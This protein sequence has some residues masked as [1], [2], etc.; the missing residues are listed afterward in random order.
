MI[1]GPVFSVELVTTTR[2]LRYLFIRTAFAALMLLVLWMNYVAVFQEGVGASGAIPASSIQRGAAFAATFFRSFAW[3]Q[4]IVVCVIGPIAV[5]GTISQERERRTIEYLFA[6]TLSNGEIVLGKLAVRIMQVVAVMAA[7]LPVLSLAMLLGGI[8]PLELGGFM[9]LSMSTLL[10]VASISMLQSVLSDRVRSA[11]TKSYSWLFALFL[12]PMIVRWIPWITKS[13]VYDWIEPVIALLVR[14][15]PFSLMWHWSMMMLTSTIW[16]ELLFLLIGH[17]VIGAGCLVI[18]VSVV[19]RSHLSSV[20]KGEK[21]RKTW[22]PR[23]PKVWEKAPLLWKETLVEPK[24]Q[25]RGIIGRLIQLVLFLGILGTVIGFLVYAHRYSANENERLNTIVVPTMIISVAL[26][27]GGVLFAGSRSAGAVCSEKEQQSWESLLSTDLSATEVV[28]GKMFGSL[29]S[30][31]PLF[32]LVLSICTAPLVLEPALVFVLVAE[33]VTLTILCQ[34]A[35]V[36]GT[37]FSLYCDSSLRAIGATICMITLIG[38]GYIFFLMPLF[39]VWEP[40][41]IVFAPVVPLLLGC[42][43]VFYIESQR[44]FGGD[45]WEVMFTYF[46]GN[47]GYLLGSIVLA[48]ATTLNFQRLSGRLEPPLT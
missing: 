8:P 15:S 27:L 44:G 33:M 32:F 36:L 3:L 18:S 13:W 5:S 43:F 46:L 17:A 4:L 7:G 42:P 39:I 48:A 40:L 6:T 2:R 38:G 25:R 1:L 45:V 9:I 23:R 10:L 20:S 31:R 16:H 34:F 28:M 11:V 12:V 37:A 41:P 24:S 21:K 26:G 14:L 47:A 22:Q 35:A 30:V 19:R 29:L